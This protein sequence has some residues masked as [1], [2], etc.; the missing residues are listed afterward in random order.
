MT[1]VLTTQRDWRIQTYELRRVRRPSPYLILGTLF[2][3]VVAL[4]TW[5]AVPAAD[6]GQHAAAIERIAAD[7]RHPSNPL[8][9]MPGAGSPY[10]TPYT[11]LLGLLSK[12]TGVPGW[13]LLKVCGP[14][15]LALVVTGIGAFT[16][17]LST[18]RWAPVLALAAFVLLWGPEHKEWS[19]FLGLQ[20]MTRGLTYPSAFAIGLT[21]WAW[22]I[23]AR[24]A[25][26]G[27]GG[28]WLH[29]GLGLLLG[30][31]LLVHPFTAMGAV[32]GVAALVLGLQQTPIVAGILGRWAL[33]AAVAFA[34]AGWWPYFSVSA[35]LG[36]PTVDGIHRQLYGDLWQWY[37]LALAGLPALLYRLRLNPLDPLV[38]MFAGDCAVAAYGWFS[39]EYSY[40]RIFGLLLVPL[41]F[42]LAVELAEAPPWTLL[43]TVLAPL[44]AVAACVGLVAQA[45]AIVPTRYVP[46]AVHLQ[47]LNHWPSYQWAQRHV[48]VGD[49]VLTD[50]YGP[51]HVMPAYGAFLVAPT[52]PDPS[53]SAAERGRR[54]ADVRTFLAPTTAP[55]QRRAIA[56]RY[57]VR[58]VMT[59]P[60]A[61]APPDTSLVAT[62][63]R[64]H[65]RLYRIG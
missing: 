64:T 42:A 24:T 3:L 51:S 28:P 41:Q 9:D 14:L 19:G 34:V 62:G 33:T 47:R 4:K 25:R 22:A 40:G 37:G 29:T 13:Q 32:I 53:T 15:N 10:F 49:V 5:D 50:A 26:R 38:L 44:A 39:G 1:G 18:R 27:V 16:R 46:P 7:W 52:W 30:V 58:W 36:D 43:R 63:P 35:L 60:K 57:H 8:L 17:T 6:F 59:A 21:F 12:L 56:R 48:A 31:I 65:E 45:G 55:D 11:V 61:P 54:A 20:S 23:T 2:W